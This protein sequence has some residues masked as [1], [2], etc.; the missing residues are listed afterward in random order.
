[1]SELLDHSALELRRMI[2]HKSLSPVEL[3]EACL[4][5][6]EAVNPAVNAFVALDPDAAREAAQDAEAAV[7]RGDELGLLHGLPIGVKDLNPTR[8]LRTTFGS[9]LFKDN[10]PESDDLMVAR[11]RAQGG[12][13]I[14]KTN[15]PEF[16]A[17][18]NTTN[19]VY[20]S[21]TNP[22]APTLS[23]AGSSG[24]S[25][26]ALATGMVPL[27]TGSDQGGSLRT[28]ASF[29]GVV[30][31]RPS[32]GAV[33]NSPSRYPW[34]PLSVDGPMGRTASDTAL[35]MAAMVG[36]TDFDPLA[37]DLDSRP[38]AAL[39]SVELQGLRV[40][41][42]ADLGFAPVAKAIRAHFEQVAGQIAPLFAST[43]WR[44]PDLSDAHWIF[45]TLRAMGF[46]ASYGDAVRDHRNRLGPNVIANAGSAASVNLADYGKAHAAQGELYRRCQSFFQEVD[47]LI[48]PAASTTPY[49]VEDV[50]VSAI[51]D[52]PMPTYI[53][54]LALA[55]G[56]TLTTHPT[57]VIPCG[58]G[59][60][61]LPFGIQ[62]VGRNRDDAG[63]LAAAAALSRA[64]KGMDGLARPRPD[65]EAL[66]SGRVETLAGRVPAT[67]EAHANGG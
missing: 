45:E 56:I 59:P 14:G 11:I 38:F 33:P 50:T 49:P 20:G 57:T 34:S 64:L 32:P 25:A 31:H 15:T 24:G 28:P 7:S 26:A 44:E 42:S 39:R 54:W 40:A 67:L 10:V 1:M 22:F 63:T 43:S 51:D 13:V 6:I 52:E 23:A 53:T 9:L 4:A 21:T 27:A 66:A 36:S 30:G 12:I 58:L 46:A 3:L 8:G 48:C 19:R 18:A 16:G 41:F 29:C 60:T 47:L 2:G 5:R 65:I 35:L 37:Q 61:G 17:G 55:Y 62:I